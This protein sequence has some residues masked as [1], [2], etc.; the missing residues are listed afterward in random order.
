VPECQS[1]RTPGRQ[2]AK[3]PGQQ[4]PAPGQPA[5][6]SPPPAARPAAGRDGRGWRLWPASCVVRERPRDHGSLGDGAK[7]RGILLWRLLGM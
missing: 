3:T 1:A 6:R 7:G 5:A 2:N 4:P